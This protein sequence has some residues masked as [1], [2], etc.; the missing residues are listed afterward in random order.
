MNRAERSPVLFTAVVLMFCAFQAGVR[1]H[2][3]SNVGPGLIEGT[4]YY[5]NGNLAKGATV[6]VV[7]VDRGFD[8][9]LP[10]AKTDGTGHFVI[11]HLWLGKFAIGAEK[12]DEDYPRMI[13][14]FYNGFKLQTITLTGRSPDVG[15]VKVLLG[16]KAGILVVHVA[17]SI[18]GAPLNPVV[19]FRWV[20][21]PN[22][23]VLGRSFGNSEYRMLVP[24]DKDVTMKVWDSGYKCWYYPGTAN[25]SQSKPVHL[26]PGEEEKLDIRLQR[27]AN[28]GDAKC[29]SD[30]MPD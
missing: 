21:D 14:A 26:R 16:P 10:H 4:V 27:V 6:Y 28:S 12:L 13:D 2:A 9:S 22:N 23:F 1:V 11:S 24:S 25:K 5:E 19:E 7:P 17:D 8:L 15:S 20:S 18:T 29:R 3:T 30:V